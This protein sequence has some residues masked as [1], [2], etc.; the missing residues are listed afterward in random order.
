MVKPTKRQGEAAVVADDPEKPSPPGPVQAAPEVTPQNTT[1]EWSNSS[2]MGAISPNGNSSFFYDCGDGTYSD[3]GP[4]KKTQVAVPPQVPAGPMEDGPAAP[5]M[6]PPALPPTD[7]AAAPIPPPPP[8]PPGDPALNAGSGSGTGA[9]PAAGGG[10]STTA[11]PATTEANQT[12]PASQ[13]PAP[14]AQQ[15]LQPTSGGGA[16]PSLKTQ[17]DQELQ[18]CREQVARTKRCCTNPVACMTTGGVQDAFNLLSGLATAGGAVLIG[19]A[20]N[21]PKKMQQ[22][23]S[24]MQAVGYGS[25]ATNAGLAAVC[26]TEISSC[27]DKCDAVK[28]KYKNM[29]SDVCPG[30]STTCAIRSH[31]SMVSSDAS[32][33]SYSCQSMNG[34]VQRM[35]T[36]AVAGGLSGAFGGLCA[37]LSNANTGFPN[38]DKQP[39]FTTDCNNPLNASNPA[40]L[41]CSLAANKSNPLCKP[42]GSKGLG[43]GSGVAMTGAP[44]FGMGSANQNNVGAN[45]GFDGNGQKAAIGGGQF[46]AASAGGV[47]N[48]GGQMLGSGGSG[49]ANSF[50]LPDKQQGRGPGY[51]TDVLQGTGGGGGY[52]VSSVPTAASG[53]FGGY[54]QQQIDNRTGKPFDLKQYLPGGAKDP[55]RAIAGLGG[56]RPEFGNKFDDIFKRINDRYTVLCRLGRMLECQNKK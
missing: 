49:G 20:G 55:K 10:G 1:Y 16:D 44:N 15:E 53:G 14:N 24:I 51:N 28:N 13:A 9:P 29:M 21:D 52:T 4:C 23:C 27:E 3:S 54:G 39:I 40:C 36:Q 33:G 46:K 18:A 35:A 7:Q 50:G 11:K 22:A 12:A 8:A 31:L 6:V 19:T 30:G 32:S 47:P 5:N 34:Q 45:A 25:G 41:N 37:N 38:L 17:A 26:Y 56:I 2:G 42:T 43:D 48:G